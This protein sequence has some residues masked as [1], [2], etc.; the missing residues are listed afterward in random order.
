MHVTRTLVPWVRSAL[1]VLRGRLRGR[2]SDL[3]DVQRPLHGTLGGAP[4]EGAAL[5]AA[6]AR[7]GEGTRPQHHFILSADVA[8]LISKELSE[9]SDL[10]LQLTQEHVKHGQ[11]CPETEVALTALLHCITG[12]TEVM[13]AVVGE[14]PMPHDQPYLL[15]TRRH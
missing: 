15:T 8:L 6:W 3:R 4:V 11:A 13:L 9:L 10:G 2:R 7:G 12:L 14:T 5:A 1:D